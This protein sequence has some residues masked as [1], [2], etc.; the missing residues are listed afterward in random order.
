[1]N[2]DHSLNC[3]ASS[4]QD[5]SQDSSQPCRFPRFAEDLPICRF[6]DTAGG[7]AG[8]RWRTTKEVKKS[9]SFVTRVVKVW[10]RASCCL[11][12]CPPSAQFKSRIVSCVSCVSCVCVVYV[13]S[14]ACCVSCV[15]VVCVCVSCHVCILMSTKKMHAHSQAV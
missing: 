7:C 1:M 4:C 13:A 10:S 14:S 12:L 8:G 2:P 6:P 15:C 3:M 9:K 11:V 5:F